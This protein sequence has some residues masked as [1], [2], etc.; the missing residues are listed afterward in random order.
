L[1][2]LLV[3]RNV[4]P[5]QLFSSSAKISQ[6]LPLSWDPGISV[7]ILFKRYGS[8][9]I[10]LLSIFS[11]IHR[12][13]LLDFWEIFSLYALL[14]VLVT[15]PCLQLLLRCFSTNLAE[16]VQEMIGLFFLS[17][18]SFV[19]GVVQSLLL[20]IISHEF[21]T[22]F[23]T[24]GVKKGTSIMS[25]ICLDLVP[26]LRCYSLSFFDSYAVFSRASALI[27]QEC[28]EQEISSSVSILNT[29]YILGEAS[30]V[31]HDIRFEAQGFQT[32]SSSG[33]EEATSRW[34]PRSS[35]SETLSSSC[36]WC[37]FASILRLMEMR[38]GILELR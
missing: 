2:K 13:P 37:F 10:H 16:V 18:N 24:A 38:L 30:A 7:D 20:R 29:F 32:D 36:E 4:S 1:S 17:Y 12:P 22:V 21:F 8:G 15:P 5:S 25:F 6:F 35:S 11:F 33:Y 19:L 23:D 27:C 9:Y 31:L 28:L 3:S 26:L 34:C 14:V